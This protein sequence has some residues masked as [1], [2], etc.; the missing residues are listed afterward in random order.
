MGV[1]TLHA[2]NIKG[3]AFQFARARPGWMTT[4]ACL[5]TP[6]RPADHFKALTFCPEHRMWSRIFHS[7]SRRGRTDCGAAHVTGKS[8]SSQ[9]QQTRALISVKI[10]LSAT[11]TTRALVSVKVI[12]SDEQQ[13]PT[14]NQ[15]LTEDQEWRPRSHSCCSFFFQMLHK[16]SNVFQ[17][18]H[19]KHN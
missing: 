10:F 8:S 4:C 2:S 7:S 11:T 12:Q 19:R 1:L 17:M 13:G 14:K 6:Q 5:R 9:L 3:F 18:L 15:L 16:C